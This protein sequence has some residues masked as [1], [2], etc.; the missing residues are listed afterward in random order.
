MKLIK[1]ITLSALAIVILVL[2]TGCMSEKQ[3]NR[4]EFEAYESVIIGMS[5]TE[6]ETLLGKPK[7][8][9]DN[10]VYYG[11]PPRVEK[12]QSPPALASIVIVYS[13]NSVVRSKNFY[14]KR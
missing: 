10:Q 5:R 3:I 7:V 1:S 12:W 13:T 14:G 2:I 8:E 9:L 11:S 4:S 6:V